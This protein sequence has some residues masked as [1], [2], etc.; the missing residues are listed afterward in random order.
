[1][2]PVI[3]YHDKGKGSGSKRR[4]CQYRI[5]NSGHAVEPRKPRRALRALPYLTRVRPRRHPLHADPL[6]EPSLLPY[7]A[8]NFSVIRP[9]AGAHL[10]EETDI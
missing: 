2:E 8:M 5:L 6:P 1:M 7:A 9:A 4:V 10:V 3:T